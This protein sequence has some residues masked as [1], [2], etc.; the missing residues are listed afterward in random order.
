MLAFL[1]LLQ[2]LL[3]RTSNETMKVRSVSASGQIPETFLFTKSSDLEDFL[4]KKYVPDDSISKI[5]KRLSYSAKGKTI[6]HDFYMYNLTEAHASEIYQ[7][8]VETK[9]ASSRTSPQSHTTSYSDG[10]PY[11]PPPPPKSLATPSHYYNRVAFRNSSI[12]KI[13][14]EG[15]NFV[16]T[17]TTITAKATVDASERKEIYETEKEG[18][19]TSVKT[20]VVKIAR[21]L[22][23]EEIEKINNAIDDKAR[24]LINKYNV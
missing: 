6:I 24:P 2:V 13:K 5:S 17:V 9:I 4:R 10:R 22:T 14:R 16:A 3:S 11:A 19:G 21:Y 12:I 15:N 20:R 1:S 23:G 18:K 8:S 7:P